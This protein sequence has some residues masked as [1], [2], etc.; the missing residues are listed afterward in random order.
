MTKKKLVFFFSFPS[1]AYLHAQHRV[2]QTRGMTKKKLVFFFSFPRAAYLHAQH[3][4]VQTRGMTK[5]KLAFLFDNG[6]RKK[7]CPTLG[8]CGGG[9]PA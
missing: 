7:G 6:G 2:V 1:A 9:G 3:R 5:K 8:C 4:V